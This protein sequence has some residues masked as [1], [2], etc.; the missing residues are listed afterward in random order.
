MC[1]SKVPEYAE[2]GDEWS[3]SRFGRRTSEGTGECSVGAQSWVDY[4]VWCYRRLYDRGRYVGLY[5]DCAAHLPDDNIYHGGGIRQGSRI[6]AVNPVLGARQVA[7]RLYC[8]LRELEPERTMI[9]Y[10]HS[11]QRDLAFLSWCDVYADGENFTSRLSKAEQDYHRVYP[12][13]AFLAQSMGQNSGPTVWF[14][15]EFNRSGA[16]TPEDWARLGPQ[17]VTHL[18]GLILLHDSTYWKAYGIPQGYAMVDAALTKYLFDDRYRMVPYW[19]QTVV[20][21]PDKVY[22]TFYVDDKARRVLMVILN[23]NEQDLDLRLSL[24]WRALGFANAE[25]LRV[26]DAVFHQGAKIDGGQLVTPVG[27]A[28][29]RLLAIEVDDRP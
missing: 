24:D 4:L 29:M 6:L 16:T 17:P 28:N 26:D 14:L 7:Q 2:W 13:D 25:R 9:V 3:P 1:D 22:S 23:N 10:H 5:Y 21:L 18:Y 19:S 11:G 12:V 15:D 8:M 20:K 27:R